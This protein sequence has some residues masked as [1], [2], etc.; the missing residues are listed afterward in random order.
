MIQY[1]S[2][3]CGHE[4]NVPHFAVIV[5]R[6]NITYT[7]LICSICRHWIYRAAELCNCRA[8]CHSEARYGVP[9]GLTKTGNV[10]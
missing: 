7:M 6:D 10:G 2:D 9:E 8:G 4:T 3:N 5:T 1:C